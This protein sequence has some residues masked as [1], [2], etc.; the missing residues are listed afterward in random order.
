MAHAAACKPVGACDS[1]VP[2]LDCWPAQEAP[3]SQHDLLPLLGVRLPSLAP[4]ALLPLLLAATL[5]LG[6]LLYLSICQHARCQ[7]TLWQPKTIHTA[8]DVLVAPLAEEWVF[9]ACMVPLLW[10]QVRDCAVR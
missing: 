6:P 5:Y 4:A 3:Q 2:A 7:H 1:C 10:L 9:R 8:R